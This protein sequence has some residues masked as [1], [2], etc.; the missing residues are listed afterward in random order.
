MGN[1]SPFAAYETVVPG[2]TARK[3]FDKIE[4]LERRRVLAF[5]RSLRLHQTGRRI[6]RPAK[7]YPLTHLVGAFGISLTHLGDGPVG[8]EPG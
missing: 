4:S 8:T 6:H 7:F 1:P 3:N 5:G 2:E